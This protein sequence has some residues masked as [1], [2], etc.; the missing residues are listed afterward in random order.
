MPTLLKLFHK[1]KTEE[2]LL[3]LF[4]EATVTLIP[5]PHKDSTKE[6]NYRL[7]SVMNTEAKILSKILEN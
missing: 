7:I 6:M 4:Y 5:K 3:N 2:T 1:I